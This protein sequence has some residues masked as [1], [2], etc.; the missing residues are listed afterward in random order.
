VHIQDH[1]RLARDVVSVA[2]RRHI[3]SS[4]PTI[5]CLKTWQHTAGDL[6]CQADLQLDYV[7]VDLDVYNRLDVATARIESLGSID[8]SPGLRIPVY[9]VSCGVDLGCFHPNPAVDRDA[10]RKRFNLDPNRTV[11]LFVGG[12]SRKTTGM[13]S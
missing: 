13:F 10:I 4:A 8:K 3:H 9:P 7:V 2:Q 1:Y 11:F 6:K 5:S 12:R